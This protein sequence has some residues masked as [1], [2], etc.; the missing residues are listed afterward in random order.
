MREGI[1]ID[2]YDQHIKYLAEWLSD[3]DNAESCANF[4]INDERSNR[5]GVYAWHGD[6]A[7]CELV[8]KA[9]G[10]VL[11]RPLYLGR[12]N[13]TLNARIAHGHLGKTKASTLRRSLAAVLWNE[14]ELRCP[15]RQTLDELSDAR[16]TDW[17]REHLSVALVPVA[18]RSNIARIEADVRDAVNPPFNFNKLGGSNG[19]KRLRALRRRHLGVTSDTAEWARQLLALH[20]AE[21]T[22]P[23]VVVPITIATGRGSRRSRARTQT[24][25]RPVDAKGGA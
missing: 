2:E 4:P 24:C 1:V 25:W 3:P 14:L 21:A 12:T 7:A 18:D 22:D 6:A 9:L 8:T 23:G 10:P 5:G 19:R 11:V 13:S 17:M 20:A 16:L 15:E